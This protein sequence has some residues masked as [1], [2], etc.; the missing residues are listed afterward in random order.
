MFQVEKYLEATG[1]IKF[2]S[3]NLLTLE[4]EFAFFIREKTVEVTKN[5]KTHIMARYVVNSDGPRPESYRF[6]TF[7]K[8]IL[9]HSNTFICT[10]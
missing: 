5:N 7:A 4:K 8:H 1:D 3:D 9:R 10:H 6:V 2:L